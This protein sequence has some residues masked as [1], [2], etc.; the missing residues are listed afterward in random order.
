MLGF[1]AN[2]ALSLLEKELINFEPEMQKT[3]INEL[4]KVSISLINYLDSKATKEVK[5]LENRSE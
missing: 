2:S 1:L 3:I 4:G 5:K